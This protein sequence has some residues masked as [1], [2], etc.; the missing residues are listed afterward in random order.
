MN[1]DLNN[2]NEYDKQVIFLNSKNGTYNDNSSFDFYIKF[3]DPIKNISNVKIIDA[4]LILESLTDRIL[5]N[6]DIYYIELNDYH[7]TFSYIKDKNMTFK[8][9]DHIYYNKS[10]HNETEGKLS[11]FKVSYPAT[12]SNWTDP[13]LYTLNPIAHNIT[14]FT[15][16]IK[17]KYLNVLTKEEGESFNMTICVYTIKKN[18]YG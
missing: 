5:D 8:Y 1:V 11:K 2:T 15:I 7:R 12:L 4:S 13:S 9:F 14:R 17:D 18:I 3:E 10:D 16:K 6:D